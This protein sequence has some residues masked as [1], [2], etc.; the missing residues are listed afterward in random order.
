MADSRPRGMGYTIWACNTVQCHKV[1]KYYT[2]KHTHEHMHMHAHDGGMWKGTKT[3]L[4]ELPRAKA[5]IILAENKYHIIG[6]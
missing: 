3:N 4:K 2:L 6:L 1:K 5:R